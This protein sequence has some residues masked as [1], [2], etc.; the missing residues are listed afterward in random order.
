LIDSRAIIDPSAKIAEGTSVG[1]YSV[2]GAEVEIGPDCEIGPHVVI[3]GPTV[4]GSGNKIQSFCAIGCMPQDKKYA[5]EATN[6]V[7]GDNN[8]IFEY[9]TI[10]RGTMQDRG[11]TYVGDE[12]WIMAHV[13]IAHDCSVGNNTIL[14]NNTTLA[15]H[16][17]VE[18]YAILGGYTLVHQFCRIGE[19]CFTQ[20]NSVIS[21]DVLPYLMI[22]GHMAKAYG[23][24]SEGLKRRGFSDESRAAMKRAYRTIF[25]AGLKLDEAIAALAESAEQHPEVKAMCDFMKNSQRGIVR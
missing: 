21:M 7:I 16:V 4:I 23:L 8:T 18:D 5:G 20:M 13:H 12:N 14:A 19:H 11:M 2:I 9:V 6:L 24:N 25:R 17:D 1:P 15:G 22:G 10:S 3:N